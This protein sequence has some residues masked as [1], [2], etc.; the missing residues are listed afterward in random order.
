MLELQTHEVKESKL[1]KEKQN[2]AVACSASVNC[3][4][5]QKLRSCKI[6]KC[7][8]FAKTNKCKSHAMQKADRKNAS[9]GKS[10]EE[11]KISL[12]KSL[13]PLRRSLKPR[14]RRPPQ[15]LRPLLK[16]LQA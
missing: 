7:A 13:K 1:R 10:D 3:E 16:P 12:V 9:G 4:K 11:N 15:A 14:I 6:G 5:E 8:L 2:C